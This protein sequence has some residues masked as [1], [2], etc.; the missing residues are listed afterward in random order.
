MFKYLHGII[1]VCTST[2]LALVAP[3]ASAD[4]YV[5]VT[6]TERRAERAERANGY[7][8]WMLHSGVVI[9]GLSYGAAAVVA[10]QSSHDGDKSLWIPV[11]GPWLDLG[12]R[13]PACPVGTSGCRG[14]TLTKVALVADGIFQAV[15]TLDILG[16]LFFRPSAPDARRA[17]DAKP[18]VTGVA[19]WVS[20]TTVGMSAGAI[21]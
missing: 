11:V 13:S 15:G 18:H 10:A 4:Q 9:L 17:Y 21:F 19:P 6:P 8:P 2:A 14:E 1:L 12:H 7:N 16:A 20:P 5:V 3:R